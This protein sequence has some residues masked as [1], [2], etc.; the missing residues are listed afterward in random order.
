VRGRSVDDAVNE[1]SAELEA[2]SRSFAAAADALAS[3]DA[4]VL[5]SRASLLD[6]EAGVAR[7]AGAATALDRRLG[8]LEAHQKEVHDALASVEA[9]AARAYADDAPALDG[10]AAERDG[11]YERTEAVAAALARAGDDLRAA[12]A[13]VNAG[14]AAAAPPA[15]APRDD[16][17]AKLV[18]V[19]NNQL[20]ALADVDD[21]CD[22]LEARLAA[23]PAAAAAQR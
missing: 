15:G 4:A 10:D 17:A 7:A 11:L 8:L 1:W 12:V 6:A 19:L 21:R 5:A 2:R 22:A 20:H 23:L 18:R 16:A 13:A 3:W 14:A 9:A